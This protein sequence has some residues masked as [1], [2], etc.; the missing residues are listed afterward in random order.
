MKI[1]FKI[2]REDLFWK[3]ASLL[4]KEYAEKIPELQR[5]RKYILTFFQRRSKHL[6]ILKREKEY[7]DIC[8]E[9]FLQSFSKTYPER[10]IQK[11]TDIKE[12]TATVFHTLSKQRIESFVESIKLFLGNNI[13]TEIAVDVFLSEKPSIYSDSSG[14]TSKTNTSKIKIVNLFIKDV[15]AFDFDS[16]KLFGIIF[17]EIA[18][19]LEH[20]SKVL[21][22]VIAIVCDNQNIAVFKD[23]PLSIQKEMLLEAIISS[24]SH[25][26][27]GIFRENVLEISKIDNKTY[28]QNF[29]F[30]RKKN[31]SRGVLQIVAGYKLLPTTREY[32]QLGKVI[33]V[34]YMKKLVLIYNNLFES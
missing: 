31:A 21:Q 8:R 15:Y 11:L 17:H 33:G 12:T 4:F 9:V 2:D 6:P 20:N 10:K 13:D 27:Y 18:H 23:A 14:S 30:K 7:A 22:Q 25:F 5:T 24:I 32:I 26:S 3:H 16:T 28:L 1:Q 34:D 29:S 19:I